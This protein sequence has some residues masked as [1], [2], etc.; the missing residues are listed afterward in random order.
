[1][2]NMISVD[3]KMKFQDFKRSELA[4]RLERTNV[5]YA[6]WIIVEGNSKKYARIKVMEE[7]IKVAKDHLKNLEDK[8]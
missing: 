7:Y 5:D 3:R 2:A 1:M 6:P 4:E 8:K